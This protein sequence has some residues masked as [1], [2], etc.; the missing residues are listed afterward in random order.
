MAAP[1]VAGFAG[2]SERRS[3]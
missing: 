3:G 2:G 1:G